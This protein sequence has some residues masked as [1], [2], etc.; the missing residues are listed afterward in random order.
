MINHRTDGSDTLK[1]NAEYFLRQLGKE[2]DRLKAKIDE[3]AS[4]HERLAPKEMK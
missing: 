4:V 3:M 1:A 2:I